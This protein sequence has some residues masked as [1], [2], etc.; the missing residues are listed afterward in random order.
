[1]SRCSSTT[2][3][4][5]SRYEF[6][7]RGLTPTMKRELKRKSGIEANIAHMKTEGRLDRSWLLGHDGDTINVL[8]AAAGH[9]LRTSP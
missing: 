6:V 3:S 7:E 5:G 9:N 8:L 2:A 4:C 1:M